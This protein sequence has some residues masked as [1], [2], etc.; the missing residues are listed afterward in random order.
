MNQISATGRRLEIQI[1]KKNYNIPLV[2]VSSFAL[3]LPV[4]Y[5]AEKFRDYQLECLLK[6]R[7]LDFDS[8]AGGVCFGNFECTKE[9][10]VVY[11]LQPQDILPRIDFKHKLQIVLAGTPTE[12]INVGEST[13]LSHVPKTALQTKSLPF[14]LFFSLF[15][16]SKKVEEN[17]S[18]RNCYDLAQK[19]NALNLEGLFASTFK[20]G[21]RSYT[22]NLSGIELLATSNYEI[23]ISSKK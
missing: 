11:K 7:G 5:D 4:E 8:T 3:S 22:L 16:G 21:N 23:S 17:L 6:Q 12:Y 15:M 18:Y 10:E 14:P 20:S 19:I 13:A 2:E 1:A 9:G